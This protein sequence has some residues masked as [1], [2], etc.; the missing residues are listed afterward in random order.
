M[1]DKT[2][3]KQEIAYYE[4]IAMEMALEQEAQYELGECGW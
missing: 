3:T 1:E 2:M 4:A